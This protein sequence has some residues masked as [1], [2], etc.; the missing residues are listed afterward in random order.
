[1]L[2]LPASSGFGAIDSILPLAQT[3]TTTATIIPPGLI[4]V[5]A[6][7]GAVGLMLL[8]PGRMDAPLRRIG[9]VILLAVGLV[10]G[11]IVARTAGGMDVYFWIF[12]AI[13]V[14]GAARVITHPKPVYSAC[15]SC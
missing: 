13:A 11:A 4:F 6:A 3:T 8:L 9:G 10:F 1:M 2:G 7:V 5:L 14:F 15:T 12:A